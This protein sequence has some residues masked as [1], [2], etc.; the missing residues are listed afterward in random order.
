MEF[1]LDKESNVEEVKNLFVRFEVESAK[2]VREWH[3]T[4]TVDTNG[5]SGGIIGLKFNPRAAIWN[6]LSGEDIFTGLVNGL[7]VIRPW[8]ADEL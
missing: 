3:F 6:E 4:R 2:E 5:D 8:R 7:I 1:R